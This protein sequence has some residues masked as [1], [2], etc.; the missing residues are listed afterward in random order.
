MKNTSSRFAL[1]AA[2]STVV[3]TTASA[4]NVL[5]SPIMVGQPRSEIFSVS[6]SPR[7]LF[8]AWPQPASLQSKSRVDI[9]TT[10]APTHRKTC[11]VAFIDDSQLSCTQSFGRAPLSY[12]REDVAALIHPSANSNAG[13]WELRA[14]GIGNGIIAGAVFL[15]SVTLA[16]A[17]VVGILGGMVALTSVAF[18]IGD[19]RDDAS[20]LY[21]KPGSTLQVS[22][23]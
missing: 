9:V 4:Q 23:W 5:P 15:A 14:L 10:A 2:L 17:I 18:A 11:H 7:P 22:L 12:H 1:I 19:N 16:G 3:T 13:L 6:R 8:D 20:L 21:L